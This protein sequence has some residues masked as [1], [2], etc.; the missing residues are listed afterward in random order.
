MPFTDPVKAGAPL[1]TVRRIARLATL[2]QELRNDYERRPNPV[3]LQQIRDR[4]T[5]IYELST[6]LPG[7]VHPEPS[8]EQPGHAE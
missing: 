6:T 3:I 1:D 5:E 8:Q 7:T 2:I 4:A